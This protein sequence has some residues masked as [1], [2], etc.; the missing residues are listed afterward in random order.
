MNR[1]TYTYKCNVQYQFSLGYVFFFYI[2]IVLMQ[3]DT[4]MFVFISLCCFLQ[5]LVLKCATI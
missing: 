1:L 3:F 5:Q 4:I 2:A